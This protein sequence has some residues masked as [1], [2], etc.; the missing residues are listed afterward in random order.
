LGSAFAIDLNISVKALLTESSAKTK[1]IIINSDYSSAK[2]RMLIEECVKRTLTMTGFEDRFDV[3][4]EINSILPIARGLKSSSALGNAVILAILDALKV[5]LKPE[6]VA[7]ININSAIASG[8]TKAGSFDDTYATL[9]GGIVFTDFYS[10]TL[11]KR[12]EM[13]WELDVILLIPP[14]SERNLPPGSRDALKCLDKEMRQLHQAAMNGDLFSAMTMNGLIHANFF[15]Y[16]LDVIVKAMENGAHAAC[17]SGKG[18]AFVAL[19][20]K[21]QTFAIIQIWKRFGFD[22]LITKVNNAG[23]LNDI[24]C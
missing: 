19:A 6:E 17:L 16:N 14:E 7:E 2:G 10:R 21:A 22:I 5:N 20:S 18:P 12:S 23:A 1:N 3:R 8:L 13:P 15:N 24:K 11:I 9:L 4:L